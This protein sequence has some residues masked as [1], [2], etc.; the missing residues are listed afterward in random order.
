[1]SDCVNKKEEWMGKG[2]RLQNNVSA[3]EVIY[4]TI[5]KGIKQFKVLKLTKLL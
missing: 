1:M 3:G 2:V 4:V 5:D